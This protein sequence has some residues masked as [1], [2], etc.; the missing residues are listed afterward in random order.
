[1]MFFS[2][3]DVI[4]KNPV[5]QS[6]STTSVKP[7]FLLWDKVY[8]KATDPEDEKWL[9]RACDA[10]LLFFRSEVAKNEVLRLASYQP[11]QTSGVLKV[12]M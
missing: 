7:S 11:F 12:L 10:A 5:L 3:D 6:I 8:Q 9:L 2:A 1:M 4:S